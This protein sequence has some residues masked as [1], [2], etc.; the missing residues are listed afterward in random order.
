MLELALKKLESEFEQGEY[1]RYA[2]IMKQS[3]RDALADFCRQNG[4]FAQAVYQGGSFAECM[5]AVARNCG[6]GLSDLEAYR[7]A[8]RFYFEG[9]DVRVTMTVDLCAGVDGPTADKPA[10]LALDL[11]DFL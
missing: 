2:K 9:A 3:V 6:N 7:R 10:G 8:V 5:K 4:E 1:D 11:T